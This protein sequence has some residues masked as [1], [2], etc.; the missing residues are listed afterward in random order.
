MCPNSE[1]PDKLALQTI[2]PGIK[3]VSLRKIDVDSA[4]SHINPMI[5]CYKINGEFII[6]PYGQFFVSYD[7]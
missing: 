6:E 4:T 3:I 5:I 2:T 7:D 1:S